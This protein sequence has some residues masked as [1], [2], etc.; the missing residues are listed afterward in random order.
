MASPSH[1]PQYMTSAR[2]LLRAENAK[3]SI[4][5]G[6]NVA[7]QPRSLLLTGG[8]GFIG[9]HVAIRL[10]QRNPAVRV[11]VLDKLDYCASLKNLDAIK[12]SPNFKVKRK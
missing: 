12:N 1:P 11:V 9:S 10:V 8:A 3:L 6:E 4:L 7:Y 2:M 5:D